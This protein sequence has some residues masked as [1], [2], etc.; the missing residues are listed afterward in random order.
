MG[1]ILVSI[2][3]IAICVYLSVGII[4]TNKC[5]NWDE[6]IVWVILL[7]PFAY[8]ISFSFSFNWEDKKFKI[9]ICIEY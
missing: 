6:D 4:L 2:I 8:S 5:N 1:D 9:G 7:W 3:W